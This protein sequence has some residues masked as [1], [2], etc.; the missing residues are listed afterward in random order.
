MGDNSSS[1]TISRHP[2]WCPPLH[3]TSIH[4]CA[5]RKFS[6]TNE[7]VWNSGYAYTVDVA[8]HEALLRHRHRVASPDDADFFYIPTYL[9]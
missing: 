7:T 9:S 6:P 5:P 1:G 4:R 2:P 8:F 3:L